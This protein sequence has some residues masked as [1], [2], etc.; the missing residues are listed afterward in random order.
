[1]VEVVTDE[2]PGRFRSGGSRGLG[3]TL[4]EGTAVLDRLGRYCFTGTAIALMPP[5]VCPLGTMDSLV[6]GG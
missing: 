3:F 1:M 6:H 4:S 2:L 5:L